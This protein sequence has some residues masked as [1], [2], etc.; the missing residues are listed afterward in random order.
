MATND[1]QPHD[2]ADDADDEPLIDG[3][4]VVAEG[5]LDSNVVF[6]LDGEAVSR[7]D[8]LAARVGQLADAVD[9]L[10]NLVLDAFEKMHVIATDP[11]TPESTSPAGTSADIPD[12]F[13]LGG[14][15]KKA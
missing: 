15:K 1:D 13:G 5:E 12:M 6:L 3:Y 7:G 4:E 11:V 10:A 2:Q 8:Y 14:D 9:L